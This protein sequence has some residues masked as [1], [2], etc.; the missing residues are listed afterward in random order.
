M[1]AFPKN[2]KLREIHRKSTKKVASTRYKLCVYIYSVHVTE[3][4][5]SFSLPTVYVFAAKLCSSKNTTAG[6]FVKYFG[7]YGIKIQGPTGVECI[8]LK[9]YSIFNAHQDTQEIRYGYGF[10][11]FDG[12][13]YALSY[14]HHI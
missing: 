5:P 12:K 8:Y 11:I 9:K 6:Y 14:I 7:F 13:N 4:I 3:T 2:L 1:R 10:W